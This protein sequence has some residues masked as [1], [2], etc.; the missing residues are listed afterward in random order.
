LDHR[1]NTD[2]QPH[3]SDAEWNGQ[4]YDSSQREAC[5]QTRHR[6]GETT[7]GYAL[8]AWSSFIFRVS[9]SGLQAAVGAQRSV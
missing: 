6:I 5:T 2:S 8:G 7:N 3:E 4:F 1:G 9:F